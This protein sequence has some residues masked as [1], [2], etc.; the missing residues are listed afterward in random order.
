VGIATGADS[1]LFVLDVDPDSGGFDTLAALE[2]EHGPLPY[3]RT[4]R[5]GSAGKHFYWRWPGFAVSNSAGKLGPG[6]DIRGNGGQVVAPPSRSAKG[7]YELAVD[8][9]VGDA[10]TW[11]LDLLRPAE[12]P[13]AVTNGVPVSTEVASHYAAKALEHEVA[14]V[15]GTPPNGGRNDQLNR[16]AFALGQLVAVDALD[17]QRVRDELAAASTDNG[18]VAKDGIH[19]MWATLESGLAKG[20]ANPRTPWPPVGYN[21]ELSEDEIAAV[22]EIYG[23]DP[24]T[25]EWL[26]GEA[27]NMA[28][29]AA[30][31]GAGTTGNHPG[32]TPEP[33]PGTS[34]ASSGPASCRHEQIDVDALL[35]AHSGL[36]E[37]VKPGWDVD[38]QDKEISELLGA[39]RRL[40]G[41]TAATAHGACALLH[42]YAD[43]AG[44]CTMDCT[45]AWDLWGGG[46]GD[47][48]HPSSWR[49]VA[50]AAILDGAVEPQK[51]TLLTRTD[52][53]RLLYSGLTHWVQGEPESGKSWVA[54]YATAEVLNDG[55]T[56]IYLDH[57]STPSA[58]VGRLL[59]LGADP[60]AIRE[61]FHYVQPETASH[62]DPVGFAGLATLQAELLVIDG[63]TD[64]LGVDGSSLLDNGEVADWMRRVPRTLARK[65]GAAVVCV[66]HV[67]KNANGGRFAI[68]AQAKLAG[69]DGAV[70]T[71]EPI[72]PLGRGMRGELVLRV[73]KDRPGEIRPHCG[74]YR[75]GD[76]TQEA[77]LMIVDST[78]ETG[79]QVTLRAPEGTPEGEPTMWGMVRRTGIMQAVSELLE[80]FPDGLTQR[81]AR[82]HVKC[83]S[84]Y[85]GDALKILVAEKYVES[86][87]Y[88]NRSNYP[89]WV[90][91]KPYRKRTDPKFN[92]E[93]ASEEEPE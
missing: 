54:L 30:T 58:V 8:A 59:A 3:T 79:I 2:R 84:E 83:R 88:E 47:T 5:T 12:R 92:S 19:A 91:I 87:P 44:T 66:D 21:G 73:G 86:V 72:K 56:V 29:P 49:P 38:W 1:G 35:A 76:R 70:Y 31:N 77:A 15:R 7:A 17:V 13:A 41:E 40:V 33:V 20:M 39:Y 10:S 45:A 14:S 51:P 6:L 36:A 26:L 48:R 61:R 90:S 63:V 4:I 46:T 23:D 75:A 11:L 89:L 52:G 43:M 60:A 65:T 25:L 37:A 24:R 68:G 50:L 18:Y 16:S 22:R 78:N 85:V 67:V 9:P 69:V 28:S 27:A 64:A 55:G 34:N 71:V 62:K 81:Q 93:S 80:R 74:G 32:T 82:N 53:H 42:R 57:E